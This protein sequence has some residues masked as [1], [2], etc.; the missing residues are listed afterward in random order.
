M[1][2]HSPTVLETEKATVLCETCLH[3]HNVPSELEVPK[4]NSTGRFACTWQISK[5]APYCHTAPSNRL[6]GQ[7]ERAGVF[8]PITQEHKLLTLHGRVYEKTPNCR[9]VWEAKESEQARNI[10]TTCFP[11]QRIERVLKLVSLTS[12]MIRFHCLNEDARRSDYCLDRYK[13]WA[14]SFSSSWVIQRAH[15]HSWIN[16]VFEET[17]ANLHMMK[18]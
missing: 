18:E 2:G 7:W 4:R 15:F 3:I 12:A 11:C 8:I 10:L 9:I 6:S 1:L 13:S 17:E 14:R 5:G 16:I